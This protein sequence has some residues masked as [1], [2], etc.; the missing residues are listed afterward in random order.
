MSL[1]PLVG[2]ADA[3]RRLAEGRRSG[4]L[5]QV[6]LVTGPRGVGKQRLALWLAQLMLC[7]KPGADP[8]GVCRAC[9]MV[10]GLVHPDLHWFVPIARPKAGE[11]GKQIEEAA[12]AIGA[13]MAERRKEPLYTQ[14][15][16]MAIHPI[17]SVRLLQQQ[18]GL[19]AVEGG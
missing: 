3:R 8:C 16:G 5:P 14:P 12:E 9:H 18:A 15:D 4:T 11:P 6:V 2:H 7:E 19:T 10:E 17:A 13:V 1:P